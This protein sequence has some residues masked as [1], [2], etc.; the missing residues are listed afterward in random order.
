[1]E[2]YY[3]VSFRKM[4]T[5]VEAILESAV[6]GPFITLEDA[7]QFEK[8]CKVDTDDSDYGVF[9]VQDDEGFFFL[10]GQPVPK[11]W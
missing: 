10:H 7:L 3:C 1:M 8:T 9:G 2:F 6:G 5:C 4:I 11:V